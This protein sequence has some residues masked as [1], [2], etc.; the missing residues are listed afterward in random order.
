MKN[1][2]ND[3]E[4]VK[5][6]P[7]ASTTPSVTS[8]PRGVI[9]PRLVPRD[10]IFSQSSNQVRVRHQYDKRIFWLLL[11][12]DWFHLFLRGS[13]TQAIFIM[14]GTWTG[15]ILAFAAIYMAIDDNHPD[16]NCGLT[17]P[18]ETKISFHGAFAFSLETCKYQRKVSHLL[19]PFDSIRFDLMRLVVISL[20]LILQIRPINRS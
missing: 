3:N 13:I 6:I 15:M 7:R 11:K 1:P 18:P 14:L 8:T 19:I 9:L 16:K 4:D 5:N 12:Y 2:A 17:E 10:H 20:L